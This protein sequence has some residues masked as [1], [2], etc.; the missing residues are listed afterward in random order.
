MKIKLGL[1]AAIAALLTT[2]VHPAGATASSHVVSGI[3]LASYNNY[4]VVPTADGGHVDTIIGLVAIDQLKIGGFEAT[5]QFSAVTTVVTWSA[6]GRNTGYEY[7][8]IGPVQAEVF[9]SD[10]LIR[11]TVVSGTAPYVRHVFNMDTET[12]EDSEGIGPFSVT[13]TAAS[14]NVDRFQVAQIYYPGD[15]FQITMDTGLIREQG[16]I[17]SGSV[18]DVQM[19]MENSYGVYVYLA[20]DVNVTAHP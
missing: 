15:V 2:V 5:N 18:L 19:T 7:T 20:R 14:G 3:T 11:E 6:D 17:V 10:A 13:W 16:L 12:W 8:E 4:S 9:T 1:A